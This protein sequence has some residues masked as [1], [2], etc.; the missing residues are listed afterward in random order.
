MAPRAQ[1]LR[2]LAEQDSDEFLVRLIAA[3]DEAEAAFV[4][5]IQ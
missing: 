5:L 2:V 4:G 1:V 3:A